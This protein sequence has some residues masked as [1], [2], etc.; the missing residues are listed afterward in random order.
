MRWNYNLKTHRKR[1]PKLQSEKSL[2][3]RKD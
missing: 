1:R 3:K 2:M